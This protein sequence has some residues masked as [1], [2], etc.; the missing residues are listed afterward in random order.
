MATGIRVFEPVTPQ[1]FS[2]LGYLLANK[3]L[4]LAFGDDTAMAERHYY[5]H[6]LKENRRQIS[7]GLLKSRHEKYR[8]FK[9]TLPRCNAECFPINFGKSLHK[10][11]E[12]DAESSNESAG[13]WVA[14][15]EG[16]P[17]K[18]YADIGAGLRP[19]VWLNCAYVEVYA[20]PT[21]DILID[22]R[23]KLPFRNQSLD[24]IGCFAVLEHTNK[25]WEMAVE[26][27]RVVKPGGRIFIDWPFLQPVHGYPS[28]YYNATREGLR[29][30]FADKFN[31]DE[32]YTEAYQ[33]P[34]Y[35]INW[36]LNA[37]LSSIKDDDMR[38]MV[39]QMTIG[40]LCKEP[41][42]NELWSK[43]LALLEEPSISMLSCGNTLVATR[44]SRPARFRI[45]S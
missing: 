41:P 39:S 12:Y 8:R 37:L 9:A 20:S 5:E 32:L 28:H 29:S 36:I 33:G 10:I 4:R 3:D 45:F 22:P 11:S 16:N 31:V 14:E 34:D 21:A 26:F 42:Q 27:A 25:P 2:P 38:T 13:I 15:L 7:A 40:D 18:L 43:L 24:G 1:N 30:L 35:T 23:C 44:K 19:I 6:G 17:D